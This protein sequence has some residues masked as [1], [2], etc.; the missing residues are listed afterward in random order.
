MRLLGL[1]AVCAGIYLYG[2][3]HEVIGI[4]VIVLGVVAT[5]K[6]TRLTYRQFGGWRPPSTEAG[7]GDLGSEDTRRRGRERLKAAASRGPGG[8]R[9]DIEHHHP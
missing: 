3:G 8:R 9:G 7:G 2:D 6:T 1:G 5:L 4:A